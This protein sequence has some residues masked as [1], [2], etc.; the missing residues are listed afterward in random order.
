MSEVLLEQ[1]REISETLYLCLIFYADIVR[2]LFGGLALVEY[3][4][5]RNF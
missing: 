3:E 5:K 2:C 1:L 4:P